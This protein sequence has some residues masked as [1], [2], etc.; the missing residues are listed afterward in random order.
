MVIRCIEKLYAIHAAK[1]G[2]F[3]DVMI[4][5]RTMCTTRSLETQH[6]L[7]KLLA[8][9]LGDSD[10][11]DSA[12]IPEN[13]EQ[14]LNIESISQLCQ[15]VAWA[16]TDRSQ[17]ISN[18]LSRALSVGAK[19]ILITDGSDITAAAQQSAQ[20]S[21]DMVCPAVW[22]VASTAKIPPPPEKI[23]GPFR[24][25]NLRQMID[26]GSLSHYDLVTTAHVEEYDIDDQSDVVDEI[27][28]DTGKWKRLDSVWQLRWT[29]C[30]DAGSSVISAPADVAR[31]ALNAL[32]RILDLHKSVD[33]R[34]VPYLPIPISK[35]IL[36]TRAP[37][38]DTNPLAT[39][40]QALLCNNADLV[41]Q[42]ADLV[43]KITRQ[44]DRAIQ[45]LYLTGIFFFACCYQ[46][47]NFKGIAKL[48]H[49]TH[50]EQHFRSGFSA[51]A[52]QD[53][54]PLKERSILGQLLPEGLLHILVNYGPER[55][56][57]VFVGGSDTPEVIW[58][59]EMRKHLIEMIRQH[60]GDFPL[61]LFQNNGTEY[62]YCPMPGVAYPR[63][64][65]E[66]FCHNY[67][68]CN[69]C[70]EGRFPDW[71]M[72]E[73][74]EV[75]RSC[76]EHFKKSLSE[77]NGSSE[78]AQ[79]RARQILE[80]KVGDSIKELRKAY[81]RLARVYHPD[82]NPSGR[83]MFESIQA[84]YE[85]LQ[86]LLE[87][88][89]KIAPFDGT[90]DPNLNA[91]AHDGLLFIASMKNIQILI[92]AQLLIC[93]RY[94]KEMRRYKYP[95][96]QVLLSC[97]RL[98]SSYYEMLVNEND[99]QILKCPFL[100]KEIA[101]LI[102]MT[103][104]L[105]FRTCL[106][107][108]LNAEELVVEEGV[109]CLTSL[110]S[111]SMVSLLAVKKSGQSRGISDILRRIIRFTVQT[112]SGVMYY[113]S[114]R[115]AA[116]S[117]DKQEVIFFDLRRCID[118]S[119]NLNGQPSD[120]E[121]QTK[122]FAIDCVANMARDGILQEKLAKSGIIWP[123]IRATLTYDVTAESEGNSANG[124]G[125]PSM[126]NIPAKN[127]VRALGM[128]SGS[129]KDSPIR[130]DVLSA[131]QVLLTDPVALMLRNQRSDEILRVLNSNTETA[132]IIWK[133]SMQKYLE[134]F[135][136]C[137]EEKRPFTMYTTIEEEFRV[138]SDFCYEELKREV[139]VGGVY[140]RIFNKH[141][142]EALGKIPNP[143]AFC[144][145]MCRYLAF[146]LN[147]SKLVQDLASFGLPAEQNEGCYVESEAF[148]LVVASL[149]ALCRVDGIVT[150]ALEECPALVVSLFLSLLNVPEELE[151][152]PCDCCCAR[153]FYTLIFR[154]RYLTLE[155]RLCLSLVLIRRSQL[156][157]PMRVFS[158][159]LWILLR[160]PT[161]TT[162]NTLQMVAK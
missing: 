92:Q 132:T 100:K 119:L 126:I 59:F 139:K 19:D 131:L 67:Y 65:K 94:E 161:F 33:N 130:D 1:I 154:K 45:K 71:P 153:Y 135:I 63:L 44:N 138:I 109:P 56:A 13:A 28:I 58:T 6:R 26:S 7:L 27:Q 91:E 51:A 62:E 17:I 152:R 61:R 110:L 53:E 78:D 88:G 49:A 160:V 12:D 55:F 23:R 134:K 118:G 136:E 16:H 104:E 155:L 75:F 69:L 14:L 98:P 10:K 85:L 72:A 107:S 140:L 54:I 159:D 36:S 158:G 76:L 66:I 149:V 162:V 137:V 114:G 120:D 5:V 145:A 87:G 21:S 146:S 141:G 4:I 60:L 112:L 42:A 108:P 9:I 52:A 46:G 123:L 40:C 124:E 57:D 125:V 105:V 157:W 34:G 64:E 116:K 150:S 80:L 115:S 70:D 121:E 89:G 99:D 95:A 156:R 25:S 68:L 111:F 3:T 79:D 129:I 24:L 2:P 30:T 43:Y 86:P 97:L 102:Q 82:K 73:P 128:L 90:S 84:S 32:T 83:D 151:V 117:M 31:L 50:L 48:L 39:L 11:S 35:R 74:V 93:R 8:V 106:V 147:M 148:L 20:V 127:S 96:Y 122:A 101:E 113:E 81:R 142:K 15:F 103:T 41:D 143:V 144:V 38:N 77:D 47:N 18:S 29:L 37:N 22:Y 133:S